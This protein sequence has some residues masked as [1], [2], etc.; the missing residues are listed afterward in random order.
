[1]RQRLRTN[2]SDRM[3]HILNDFDTA[4]LD[5]KFCPEESNFQAHILHLQSKIHKNKIEKN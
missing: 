5:S 1:M 4:C 3:M 2:E